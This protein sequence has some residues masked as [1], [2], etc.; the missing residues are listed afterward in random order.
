M[1]TNIK[2]GFKRMSKR[3]S[4][5]FDFDDPKLY[6]MIMMAMTIVFVVTFSIAMSNCNEEYKELK[7]NYKQ[8]ASE[9]DA[10]KDL[11]LD[12]EE[13]FTNLE[14]KNSL[15]NTDKQFL[16]DKVNDQNNK[17]NDLNEEVDQLK[18]DLEAKKEAEKKAAVAKANNTKKTYTPN[19]NPG[20]L[21]AAK[22]VNYN[23][24]GVKE[25]YYNLPMGGVVSI[26]KSQG[27]EGEYWVRDDGVKMYGDKVIVGA[28]FKTYP[29][30]TVVETS[31]GTGIVLDTGYV[32]EQHFDIAVDW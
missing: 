29:R 24:N 11:Y 20:V 31:L 7:N 23:S 13:S 3:L 12:L 27:I 32:G 30:G 14:K 16:Q 17:I 28:N 10:Q 8:L 26:A 15:L 2:K 25:T 18:K 6:V 21:T 1:L 22:G 4:A 19:N 9:S 5:H